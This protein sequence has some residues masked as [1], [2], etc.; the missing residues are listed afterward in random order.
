MN[1][2]N[3][4]L[5]RKS[6]QPD[7]TGVPVNDNRPNRTG[8]VVPMRK[9]M[10]KQESGDKNPFHETMDETF[11]KQ[12]TNPVDADIN[13]VERTYAPAN[14]N[15]PQYRT[16]N[17]PRVH[18]KVNHKEKKASTEE[19]LI[20]RLKLAPINA[21][22]GSWAMFWYLSFQLPLALISI[23][24]LGMA[25]V[26]YSYVKESAFGFVLPLLEG[27]LTYTNSFA[28]AVIKWAFSLFGVNFD[29]VLIFIAPFA[30]ML[31]L[32]IFQ[33]LLVWSI[34]SLV[35]IKSLSGQKS[36][37]KNTLFL[38]AGVGTIIPILNIFPLI[39]LWMI[40]VWKNPN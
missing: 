39:F 2:T 12:Y 34:Y 16:T 37:I 29:P 25:A 3:V 7:S 21:W 20:A 32:G 31:I 38:I 27:A 23:G 11:S 5:V 8:N 35:G 14:Q 26:A 22:V 13:R 24:G 10:G 18:K 6:P 30:L 28:G 1:T 40:A 19:K 9:R 33:L 17:V 4:Q 15:Q 36:G